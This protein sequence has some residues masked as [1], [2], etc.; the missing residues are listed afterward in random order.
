[1]RARWRS[2]PRAGR[3]CA[4][5][6]LLNGAAWSLLI[7]PFQVPDEIAH[8]YY[9]TYLAN[10]AKLPKVSTAPD[11]SPEENRLFDV[12]YFWNIIGQPRNRGPLTDVENA[13]V[14]AVERE[15]LDRVGQGDA[16]VATGNPPLYYA[17]EAVPYWVSPSHGLLDR[18]VLMRLLS[19]LMSAGTVLAVYLFL[20]TLLPGSPWAWT[21]GA[22]ALVFQP[23]F[24]FMSGGINNDSL[25]WLTSAMVFLLLAR[26]FRYGL[27]R[28]RAIA[29][30]LMCAAAVLSKLIFLGILPGVGVALVLLVLQAGGERRRE[31]LRNA[32]IAVACG[33]V[34]VA[35]YLGLAHFVWDRSLFNPGQVSGTVG[36]SAHGNVGGALSYTWQLFLPRLP[37]MYHWFG[38]F[39]L[40]QI[41][42]DGFIGR[43]GWVDYGYPSWVYTVAWDLGIVL[44]VLAAIGLA[45]SARAL[46]A[47]WAELACYVAAVVGEM[48]LIGLVDYQSHITG[49]APYEQARYLLPLAPL[50][51]A[52]VAIAARAGGRRFGPALGAAIV[53]V[54]LVHS[55][56]GQLI[57]VARYYG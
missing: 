23:T 52:V 44:V 2:I 36:T 50:Y 24:G 16:S 5:I 14:R 7:P 1:V 51:A 48:F 39:P 17:L 3:A 42:F 35:I 21:V 27:S 38:V 11:L 22:L 15:P 47:R 41:W 49:Q 25:L 13:R 45:R 6:A 8:V 30:G 19:A 53:M 4:L 37:S 54:A 10:T 12:T 20:R 56:F 33:A 32:G 40:H 29:L 9:A 18:M 55:V 31:V 43:F 28:G 34:P 46:R 26:T 57:T